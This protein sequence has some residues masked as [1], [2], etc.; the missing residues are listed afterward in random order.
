MDMPRE[1][2]SWSAMS[3]WETSKTEWIKRYI[4]NQSMFETD[5]LRL[6]KKFA[7]EMEL[8]LSND[9]NFQFLIELN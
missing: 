4:K 6:G 1:Y 3:C 2:V 8:G 5:A 7:S 9:E